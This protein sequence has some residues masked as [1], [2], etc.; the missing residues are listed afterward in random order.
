M[1]DH[2]YRISC[3][4]VAAHELPRCNV[5]SGATKLVRRIYRTVIT[6]DYTLSLLLNLSVLVQWSV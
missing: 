1:V 6:M 3:L 5:G 2:R 4:F